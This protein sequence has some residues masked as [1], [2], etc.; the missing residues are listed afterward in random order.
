MGD[1][2]YL[3]GHL[4]PNYPLRGSLSDPLQNLSGN[5]QNTE[6]LHGG[7]TDLINGTDLNGQMSPEFELTGM[8]SAPIQALAG[9]LS[10]PDVVQGK[11]TNAVLRGLSA[12]DIAVAYGG[13]SGTEEEWIESLK[14]DRIELRNNGGVIE[15]K[16]EADIVWKELINLII[17]NDYENCI[18]KPMID[19]IILS[20]NR[21]LSEDYVRNE[22]ALT[23]MEIERLLG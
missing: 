19:N 4:N 20:G 21:D 3:N 22:N 18:N 9:A 8:L 12:Y 15:W 10:N 1:S 2:I 7:L 23:N 6:G 13:Y 14:G 17:I 5:L 16:Y 11:L